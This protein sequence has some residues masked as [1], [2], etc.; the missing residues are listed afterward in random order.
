M[1]GLS[2]LAAL[3]GCWSLT[4]QIV[5]GDGRVD[6]FDGE[7]LFQRSGA[8][9]IQNESGVLR[10]GNQTFQG[11][12][13]YIWDHSDGLLRVFFD[14]MRPFHTVALGLDRVETTHLCD[15]DRYNVVY[16]FHDWPNWTS[17]WTVEGP[18]KDYVM[19]SHM[20][21]VRT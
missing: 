16:D 6:H 2:S 1:P 7:V 4:R 11:Q 21:P 15:P 3:E 10:V 18:R 17:T 13:Q 19:T 5:H 12:R 20:R 14:D 8:R 9:M